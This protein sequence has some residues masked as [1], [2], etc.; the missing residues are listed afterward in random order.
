MTFKPMLAHSIADIEAIRFPV[1]ASPKLDGI[2]CV[3]RAGKVLTRSLKPVPNH[4]V[5]DRFKNLPEVD[6]E[7]ILGDPTDP[8]VFQVTTSA[9]MS[10]DGEPDVRFHAFDSLT[11]PNHRFETRFETTAILLAGMPHAQVVPHEYIESAARLAEYEEHIVSLGYEGVMVRDP[12][13][14]YKFGRSTAKQGILGK[15]KRFEDAEAT[16]VGVEE[17]HRNTN[18]LDTNELGYAK[19]STAKGGMVA[20][21]TLGALV[22]KSAEFK[23]TFNIGTG[24]TQAQRD[25]LWADES[26]IGRTVK[27]KFQRAGVKDVPRLPVFLGFRGDE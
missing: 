22:V 12:A 8:R 17:L 10:H 3:V 20:A 23:N 2:R 14:P 7:L 13:G 16:I 26:L 18:D 11:S 21:G 27:F 19:R 5:R 6:G 1:M 24:F 15:L 9:V 25:A 4:F